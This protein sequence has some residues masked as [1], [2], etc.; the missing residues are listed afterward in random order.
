MEQDKLIDLNSDSGLQLL[1]NT[2]NITQFWINVH[3]EYPNLHEKAMKMLLPFST[4]YLCESAFSAMTL[5]MSKERNRLSINPSLRLALT[6]ISPRIDKLTN[7]K[8]QQ[9]SH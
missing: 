9:Q 4:T 7:E 1:F 6:T 3:N 2:T 8:N 5:I